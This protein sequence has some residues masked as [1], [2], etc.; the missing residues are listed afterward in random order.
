MLAGSSN[1]MPLDYETNQRH[2]FIMEVRDSGGL[3]SIL[4]SIPHKKE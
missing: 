2:I 4:F 1:E 3:V